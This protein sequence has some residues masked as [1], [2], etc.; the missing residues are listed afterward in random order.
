M[1]L[2]AD[3][4][5]SSVTLF[6]HGKLKLGEQ[7]PHCHDLGHVILPFWALICSSTKI[8]GLFED[9]L[10]YG[11]HGILH[12][13]RPVHASCHCQFFPFCWGLRSNPGPARALCP[14]CAPTTVAFILWS[15]SLVNPSACSGAKQRCVQ[16]RL[17]SCC[18]FTLESL[19]RP[20]CASVPS[21]LKVSQLFPQ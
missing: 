3:A 2:W 4:P 11:E 17:Y 5:N 9:E 7:L 13:V 18:I 12:R 1:S 15:H 19:S 8:L 20:L 10:K 16:L 21:L 6:S 14:N